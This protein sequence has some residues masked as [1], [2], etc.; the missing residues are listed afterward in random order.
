MEKMEINLKNPYRPAMRK[1]AER[2]ERL[3][4]VD[5]AQTRVLI[6]IPSGET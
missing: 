1:F 6:W 3:F 4:K 2:N 5:R